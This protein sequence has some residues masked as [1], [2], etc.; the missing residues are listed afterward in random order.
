LIAS[1]EIYG[2]SRGFNA[3]VLQGFHD[4]RRGCLFIIVGYD[5]G[6]YRRRSEINNT[7]RLFED[8]PY[9][10]PRVSGAAIGNGYLHGLFRSQDCLL[11]TREPR[12]QAHKED[13]QN[14]RYFF[15]VPLLRVL[16]DGHNLS[17][18]IAKI[19]RKFYK[20]IKDGLEKAPKT[21]QV[22]R[23]RKKLRR[24]G[25]QIM[26]SEAYMDIR[27]N[28]EGHSATQHPDFLRSRQK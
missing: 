27:R 15:H 17:T 4:F 22:R 25:A 3:A 5:Q 11:G 13:G 18:N 1:V 21:V 26:R 28:D 23:L 7:V 20:A 8:S 12:R 9:P 2:L 24:Q 10:R 19:Q 14:D 16:K 6:V